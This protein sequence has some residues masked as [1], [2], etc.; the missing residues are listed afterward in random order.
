[1]CRGIRPN[2][3][4]GTYGEQQCIDCAFLEEK[5]FGSN[6]ET[7]FLKHCRG[8]RQFIEQTACEFFSSHVASI[9]LTPSA[10]ILDCD[11]RGQSFLRTGGLFSVLH[12]KLCCND[13]NQDAKVREAITATSK[14]GRASTLLL[15]PIDRPQQRYSLAFVRLSKRIP[16]SGP[17]I[18]IS[19]GNVLCI[20]APLDRRRIA[21]A[22]QLMDLF[23]LS[24]AEARL[25][26]A[27]CHGDSLEEY[28][29][30]QGLKLPTVKT[31]LRSIF[32]KTGTERQSSLVRVL[33][34]VPVVRDPHLKSR[35]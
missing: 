11:Q 9:L 20:V 12:N 23:G 8:I 32:A 2:C 13:Q 4:F 18:E 16:S 28:A 3:R 21:T 5:Q 35:E 7:E 29:T 19:P 26:R 17:T 10:R 27:L 6:L 1:M 31:Q 24:A 30:D 15:T 34:G 14:T 33:L 22:N 25:A